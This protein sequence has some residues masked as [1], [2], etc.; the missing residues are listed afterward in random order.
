MRG[1]KASGRGRLRRKAID[2]VAR[3]AAIA[4]RLARKPCVMAGQ[5]AKLVWRI[6]NIGEID[7][8]E[9]RVLFFHGEEGE[10]AALTECQRLGVANRA[11]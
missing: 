8:V 5:R 6:Y 11:Q 10:Q 3:C 1:L 4:I 9:R 2:C 7:A